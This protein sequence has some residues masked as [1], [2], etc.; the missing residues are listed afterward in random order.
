MEPVQHKKLSIALMA[1]GVLLA[2]IGIILMVS[3][4]RLAGVS[5]LLIGVIMFLIGLPTMIVLAGY[6]A[7]QE[8]K[9]SKK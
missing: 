4:S 9:N 7:Q 8:W 1:G 3:V 6:T 2:V 5:L